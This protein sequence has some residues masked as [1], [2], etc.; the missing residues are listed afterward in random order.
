MSQEKVDRY[1]EQ[2][3]NRK[4]ILAKKKR[5]V[6]LTKCGCGLVVVLL[7]AWLGYSAVDSYYAKANSET[8]YADVTALDEYNST[9]A[10]GYIIG[11][12]GCFPEEKRKAAFLC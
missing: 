7:A 4:A 10:A 6:F 3:K 1:K 11:I 2:K 8:V 12:R 9:V 5:N